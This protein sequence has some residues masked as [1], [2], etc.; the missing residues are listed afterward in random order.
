MQVT[1]N[2][3]SPK[4]EWW[5]EYNA[6]QSAPKNRQ[7]MLDGELSP[8]ALLSKCLKEEHW[9][10]FEHACMSIEVTTSM[11]I[12]VQILRHGKGFAFQQF[13]QR[14]A[15]PLDAGLEYEDIE[16]RRQ[17][18]DNRQ[19]SL[20]ELID[21]DDATEITALIKEL[22]AISAKLYRKL[23]A[24]GVAREVARNV[25]LQ[26]IQTRFTM[27]GPARSY[28]TYLRTRLKPNTQ[29]EHRLVALAIRDIFARDFP[30]IAEV[31]GWIEA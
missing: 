31:E 14:Y 22:Q 28:I 18:K 24:L 19:G 25:L 29:K 12:C 6:R 16:L 3:T 5:I 11:P 21:G 8:G 9:S 10:P 27:T 20:D 4:P 17:S 13:S 2:W 23:L 30:L 7:R 26:G 15:N 1:H